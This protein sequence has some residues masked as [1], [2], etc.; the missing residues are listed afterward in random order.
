MEN[1][2]LRRLFVAHE[3]E[4]KRPLRVVRFPF[5]IDHARVVVRED[6]LFLLLLL[7]TPVERA[8]AHEDF[9]VVRRGGS[10]IAKIV[11]HD[12]AMRCAMMMMRERDVVASSTLFTGT[13]RAP[14]HARAGTDDD[15]DRSSSSKSILWTTTKERRARI[16]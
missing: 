6:A 15:D 13:R 2:L 4:F 10:A 7:G 3:I 11:F 14:P 5:Q 12:D 1:R 8:N 16:M 9:D